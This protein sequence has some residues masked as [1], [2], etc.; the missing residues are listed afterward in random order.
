ME[1]RIHTTVLVGNEMEIA[2]T[3]ASFNVPPHIDTEIFHI[4]A[5]L[6]DICNDFDIILGTP[7]LA[8]INW[9]HH[10]LEL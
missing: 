5:L 2:C 4:N 9:H 6:L 7:W 3:S 1:R 8:D 10:N